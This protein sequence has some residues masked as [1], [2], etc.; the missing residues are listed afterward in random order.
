MFEKNRTNYRMQK[1]KP[2]D[3]IL[4][5]LSKMTLPFEVSNFISIFKEISPE[6]ISK[7][8]QPFII[9]NEL[10][11]IYRIDTSSPDINA[12][13]DLAIM[14]QA[15]RPKA[16]LIVGKTRFYIL[17]ALGNEF[18]ITDHII[19]QNLYKL[20]ESQC[21]FVKISSGRFQN[22]T[23]GVYVSG[24]SDENDMKYL[25]ASNDKWLFDEDDLF[26]HCRDLISSTKI[27][28]PVNHREA[29]RDDP[30]ATENIKP[31]QYDHKDQKRQNYSFFFWILF[32]LTIGAFAYF[33]RD[34][35]TNWFSNPSDINQ[36]K[37]I[38]KEIVSN[39]P[40]SVQLNNQHWM[41]ENL[42][43]KVFRNGD[44]ILEAHNK[45]EWDKYCSEKKPA[46]CHWIND[47]SNFEKKGILYNWYAVVDAR[48]ICPE[49]YRIPT[50]IDLELL[51]SENEYPTIAQKLNINFSG[52]RG[53]DGKFYESESTSVFW[54]DSLKYPGCVYTLKVFRSD[55]EIKMKFGEQKPSEGYSIRCIKE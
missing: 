15:Y 40:N 45:E 36:S 17:I 24:D 32:F 9:Q 47:S 27:S 41:S 42:N 14:W 37:D 34:Q 49:G 44:S 3:E 2:Y 13:D 30:N 11:T 8:I 51:I 39:T 50:K 53:D 38:S 21:E 25:I 22:I 43:V 7:E 5:S 46:F 20:R 55:G 28:E 6:S 12:F 1:F 26:N 16:I 54:S 33:N 19:N 48:N 35:I 31:S 29:N 4:I 10:C 18:T 23:T 52:W